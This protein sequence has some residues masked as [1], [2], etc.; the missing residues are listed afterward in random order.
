MAGQTTYSTQLEMAATWFRTTCLQASKRWL[1]TELRAPPWRSASVLVPSSLTAR[2]C[3]RNLW[4]RE[5]CCPRTS[6]T[7]RVQKLNVCAERKKKQEW[8][9]RE[10]TNRRKCLNFSLPPR[11]SPALSPETSRHIVWR[12]WLFITCSDERWLYY[13]FTLPHLYISL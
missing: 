12:T 1:L 6:W 10:H 5:T 3:T 2:P 8:D 13:K 9:G 11:I 7:S 4:S